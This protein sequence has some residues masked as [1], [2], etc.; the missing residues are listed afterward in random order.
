LIR[1][2]PLGANGLAVGAGGEWTASTAD[3]TI[4]ITSNNARVTV[5]DPISLETVGTITVGN[6]P[7]GVA[8]SRDDTVYVVNANSDSL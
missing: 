4:Y 7:I 5:I 8:V 3:D 6:Y 2:I 1:T